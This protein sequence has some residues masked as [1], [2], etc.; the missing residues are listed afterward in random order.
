MVMRIIFP[1][2]FIGCFFACTAVNIRLFLWCRWLETGVVTAAAFYVASFGGGVHLPSTVGLSKL[3]PA[4]L[5]TDPVF[6]VF[7]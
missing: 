2:F 6:F 3:L 7:F 4:T 1:G 5:R